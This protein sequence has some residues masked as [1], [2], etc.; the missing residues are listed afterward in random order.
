[1]TDHATEPAVVDADVVEDTDT[2]TAGEPST[3]V[4][5]VDAAAGAIVHGAAPADIIANATEIATVL[6]D[7]IE[8]RGLAKQLG[9]DPSRKYIEVSGWQAL[10]T[11]LGALGGQPLHAETQWTRPIDGGWE[12][13][14]E[15]RTPAGVVVGR[16]EAMCTRAE[17][18]WE[19]RADYALRSMA[20]T[21]AESR[22]FRRAAGW[23]VTL[24]GYSPTP[25]E[26]IPDTPAAGAPAASEKGV[27]TATAAAGYVLRA[28]GL[29]DDHAAKL[30]AG[31][32]ARLAE[33]AGGA[34][35]TDHTNA[36]IA[37]GDALVQNNKAATAAATTTAAA[38]P[39][40]DGDDAHGNG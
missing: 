33:N 10:G 27:Q 18:T 28:T 29:P 36:L 9:K 39:Q 32:L 7:V 2:T 16:A 6:A 31:V 25:A 5:V 24:A 8:K 3:A 13:C 12:A 23:I 35:T 37:L 14:V 19:H 11:M 34:L 15:I 1:M 20:E 40:G 17:R 26:E 30:A 21:R 22:A 4:A 38:E